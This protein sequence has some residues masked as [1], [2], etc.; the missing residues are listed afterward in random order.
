MI[1]FGLSCK[2]KQVHRIF[3]IIGV[4]KISDLQN[5]IFHGEKRF[6]SAMVMKYVNLMSKFEVAI[7]ISDKFLL[8]PSLLPNKQKECPVVCDIESP[9]LRKAMNIHAYLNNDVYRRQYLMSYTPSGF[10]ARLLARYNKL[11]NP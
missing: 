2:V 10:W 11:L 7:K 4:L 9:E 1:F 6:P 5:Q 3:Y 8:I